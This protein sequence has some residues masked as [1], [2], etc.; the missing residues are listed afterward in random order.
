M[1]SQL[2]MAQ[3]KGY[4]RANVIQNPDWKRV[5]GQSEVEVKRTFE[6]E[7]QVIGL[8]KKVWKYKDIVRKLLNEQPLT[9]DEKAFLKKARISAPNLPVIEAGCYTYR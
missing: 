9:A 7:G 3:N 8:K 1:I 2:V 6:A 4:F 5:V